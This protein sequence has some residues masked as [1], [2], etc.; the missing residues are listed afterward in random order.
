[1]FLTIGFYVK[2]ILGTIKSQIEIKRIFFLDGI[3]I[4]FKRCCLQSKTLDKLIFVNKN[5]PNDLKIDYRSPFK[6]VEII[7]TDVNLKEEF[8]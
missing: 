5:G 4:S 3:L 1:M 6:L 7:E 2:Q 8:E